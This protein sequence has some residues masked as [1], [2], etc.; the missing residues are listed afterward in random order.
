[1]GK[2]A[3]PTMVGAFVLGSLAIVVAVVVALGS[4]HLFVREHKFVLFFSSD[5]NGLNVG[6][7]VKFRGVE[8]GSVANVLLS[9]GGLGAGNLQQSS[10]VRIPVII[11]LDSRKILARGAE[12]DLDDPR[13]IQEAVRLGLRGELK[14]ESLLTGLC[15]IDLDMHPNTPAKYYLGR[16][17]P[18]P[19]IPTVPTPLEQAQTALTKIMAALEKV[20]FDKLTTTLM[21]TANAMSDLIKSQ[22]LKNTLISL[23]QAAIA[24]D[25]TSKS[26]KATSDDLNREV[27]PAAEDLRKTTAAARA[28]LQQTQ[29][30]LAAVQ[31]TLGPNSPVSYELTHTLE[32]TADAAR[33][34]R[35]LSD[36]L[37]RNPSSL[38]RGRYVGDNGK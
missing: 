6:A 13:Q 37:Q 12:L 16:N 17:S 19:E 22:E 23:N 24:L 5:V 4:S 21:Q 30:T 36:Y 28:A 31:A 9:L 18:Y 15:Y 35:Q 11:Q 34:L 20:D 2:K 27:Q 29:D 1:M 25:A 10:D 26:I 14:T 8:I 32:Q 38:V 7:P 3:S 33:S